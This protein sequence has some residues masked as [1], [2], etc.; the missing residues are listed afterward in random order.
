[1]NRARI[2]ESCLQQG[3]NEVAILLLNAQSLATQRSPLSRHQP[4]NCGCPAGA[5]VLAFC[6]FTN[7]SRHPSGSVDVFQVDQPGRGSDLP[8]QDVEV[9]GGAVPER[10]TM[11]CEEEIR[12]AAALVAQHHQEFPFSVELGGPPEIDH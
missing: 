8:Q 9:Y 3:G 6:T 7:R 1:V 12:G 10:V 11:L 4:V 5:A 2:D